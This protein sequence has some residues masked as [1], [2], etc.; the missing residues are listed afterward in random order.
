[1]ALNIMITCEQTIHWF[2]WQSFEGS[3]HKNMVLT[4]PKK[5]QN[6]LNNKS[7]VDV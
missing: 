4:I 2:Q 5:P 6:E 1:M 3:T 7:K